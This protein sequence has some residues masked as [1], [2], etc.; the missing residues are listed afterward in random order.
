MSTTLTHPDGEVRVEELPDGRRLVQVTLKNSALFMPQGRWATAY[1]LEL[2]R[3]ILEVKGPAWLC[4]EMMR[5]ED[6][7]YVQRHLAADLL[8]YLDQSDFAGKRIL[9]FGCGSGASTVVLARMLPDA[10]IVGIELFDEL[11]SVARGRV[12]HYG[13]SRIDLRQSPSGT[14]LPGGLG[15]FDFVILSAVYEH[16]L[17]HERQVILPQVWSLLREG[18]YLFI[19]QTPNRLFPVELHTTMLPFINYLPSRLALWSAHRFSNRIGRDDSWEALLRKGIRG[20][21]VREIMRLLP[22][23]EG[24]PVLLEPTKQELRDRVDLWYST[25][26]LERLRPLKAGAKALIK[27]LNTATGVALVPDL[28]L[29]FQKTRAAKPR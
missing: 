6:P 8:A 26:N 17:P 22:E 9:D 28:S 3:R 20:A 13:F 19:N 7:A 21:T 11:L 25:T 1:P 16:L 29:A 2:I 15:Q 10:E 4:D 23:K 24:P 18:G 5:D 12:Q 27:M 14:Q